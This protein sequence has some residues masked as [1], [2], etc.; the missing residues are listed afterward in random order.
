MRELNHKP[1]Q[2]KWQPK[3]LF[4]RLDSH[5]TRVLVLRSRMR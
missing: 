1:P 4:G 3:Q 5:S 2:P